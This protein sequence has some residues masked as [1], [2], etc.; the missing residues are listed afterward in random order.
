NFLLDAVTPPKRARCN[1]YLSLVQNTGLLVGGLSGAIAIHYLPADIGWIHLKYPFWTLLVISFVLRAGTVL[2]FLPRFREVRDVPKIGVVE[3]LYATTVDTG[4]S[5]IN[6]IVGMV[7]RGG[8][9]EEARLRL[10]DPIR[11]QQRVSNLNHGEQASLDRLRVV[12]ARGH[13]AA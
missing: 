1:A 11:A 8:E 7:Q 5:A 10:A 2:F 3:M 13:A 12:V 4:E 6:L 9:E